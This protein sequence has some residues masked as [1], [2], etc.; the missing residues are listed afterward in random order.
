M[1]RCGICNCHYDRAANESDQPVFVAVLLV[2]AGTYMLFTA[3][4]IAVLKLL[5]KTH[6]F[7][8][9][10]AFYRGIDD[11]VPDEAE[12]GGAGKHLYFI[13]D[14]DGHGVYHGLYVC[15]S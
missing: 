13:D 4:S 1:S 2:I 8:Y 9:K 10:K 12:C 6:E 14:G 3:G 5:R 7:Y 11:D 15:G